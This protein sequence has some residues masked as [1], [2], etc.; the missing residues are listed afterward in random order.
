MPYTQEGAVKFTDH[1][2]QSPLE[3]MDRSCMTC[4]RESEEKLK[5]IVK[6]KYQRKE[7]LNTITMDNLAKAHLEA[8]KAWEVGASEKEMQEI[9]LD[10][11]HA[12]WRWDYSIASHGAFFHAP[13]ETLRVLASA[14]DIAQQ[15]RI[16]LVG[17]LAAHGVSKYIAPDFSTK[18]KAQT[19]AGV[20]YK[21]FVAEKMHFKETLEKEWHKNAIEK[22]LLDPKARENID[23]RSSYFDKK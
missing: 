14:N 3:T 2:I 7:Y 18:E 4:H 1:Q 22:G 5:G 15:A 13:E 6:T 17:V 8:A 23:K 9:L 11:R 20:D 10:L 12:S 21:K 19:L 16:K